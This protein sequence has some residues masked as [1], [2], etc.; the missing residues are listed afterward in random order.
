MVVQSRRKFLQLGSLGVAAAGAALTPALTPA[1]APGAAAAQQPSLAERPA[2]ATGSL[3]DQPFMAYVK[4][5]RSGEIVVMVGEHEVVYRDADL[6][7]RLA[8]IAGQAKK[9]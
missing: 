4:D 6:A 1:L 8:G 2:A 5:H 7:R 9:A 3:T